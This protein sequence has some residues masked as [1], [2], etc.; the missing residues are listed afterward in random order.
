MSESLRCW[1]LLQLYLYDCYLYDCAIFVEY[2]VVLRKTQR[3]DILSMIE[4]S[5]TLK[6]MP[7][8]FPT[9]IVYSSLYVNRRPFPIIIPCL[10]PTDVAYSSLMSTP[11]FGRFTPL[12]V[13]HNQ[14]SNPVRR[15]FCVTKIWRLLSLG[16]GAWGASDS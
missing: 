16:F 7:C 11:D 5:A 6:C 1:M 4:S 14:N 9:D 8:L 13:Y 12:K 10:F 3:V 2:C 15:N